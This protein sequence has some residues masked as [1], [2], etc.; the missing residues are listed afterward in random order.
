[1]NEGRGEVKFTI[2]RSDFLRS[3]KRQ[4]LPQS[5]VCESRAAEAHGSR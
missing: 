5:P 3:E 4:Q 1:M 2:Y